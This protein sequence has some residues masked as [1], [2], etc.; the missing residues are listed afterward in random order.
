MKSRR[1]D[2]PTTLCSALLGALFSLGLSSVVT[3]QVP[4]GMTTIASYPMIESG[5]DMRGSYGPLD[6]VNTRFAGDSGVWCNGLYVHDAIPGGSLV[7]TPAIST[8][9]PDSFAIA[10]EIY[11]PTFD[12]RNHT[13]VVAGEDFRYLGCGYS[14]QG[15]LFAII[16][17][18]RF[19]I[20]GLVLSSETWYQLAVSYTGADSTARLLLDGQEVYQKTT[21]LSA[22]VGD[23]VISNTHY[24]WGVTFLGYMRNLTIASPVG[25]T[26]SVNETSISTPFLDLSMMA[27]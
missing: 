18:T 6:L 1:L 21:I 14:G 16:N 26:T 8:L 13:I 27:R 11:V 17:G 9:R 7:G 12:G 19:D 2:L 20:E 24:G 25:S 4:D 22:F 23:D 3:A 10:V 5:D 15:D